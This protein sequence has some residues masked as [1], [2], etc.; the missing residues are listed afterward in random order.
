M[1]QLWTAERAFVPPP[2]LSIVQ[3]QA[4]HT[5]H[6]HS[7]HFLLQAHFVYPLHLPLTHCSDES[8]RPC[9]VTT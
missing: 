8:L 1:A 5:A 4:T 3:K 7:A 6:A 9:C 2:M